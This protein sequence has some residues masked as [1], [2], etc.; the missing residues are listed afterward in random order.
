MVDK[1]V[2]P[3]N[4]RRMEYIERL[5]ESLVMDEYYKIKSEYPDMLALD[6]LT[7]ATERVKAREE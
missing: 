6:R 7:L 4:D 5:R 1:N 3:D 2:I